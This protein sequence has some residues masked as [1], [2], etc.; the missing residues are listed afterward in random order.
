MEESEKMICGDSG[1]GK[2]NVVDDNKQ[3]HIVLHTK[4]NCSSF[5]IIFRRRNY[6]CIV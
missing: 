3:N 4:M 6:F 1:G 2:E 5:L